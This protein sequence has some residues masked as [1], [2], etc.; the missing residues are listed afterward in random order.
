MLRA[1]EES[2]WVDCEVPRKAKR[3]QL[4]PTGLWVQRQRFPR[5]L[6]GVDDKT[7]HSC[8]YFPGP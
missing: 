2:E 7:G 4:K 6:T 3:V 5:Q 1:E 8:F